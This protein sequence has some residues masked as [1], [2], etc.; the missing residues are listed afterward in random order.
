MIDGD[1]NNTQ[2]FV[3]VRAKGSDFQNEEGPSADHED[4]NEGNKLFQ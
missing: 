4:N 3:F 2:T 1:L